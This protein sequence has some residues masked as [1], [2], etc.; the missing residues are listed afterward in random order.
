[1]EFIYKCP[2]CD[3]RL[4]LTDKSFVCDKL[5]TYDISKE[6]YVNLLLANQKNSK[7]PGDDKLMAESRQ[8]FLDK[9]YYDSLA[10]EIN[11]T[12][13]SLVAEG[14]RHSCLNILDVGCGVGFYS[15][16][17]KEALK[18]KGGE[19]NVKLWGIDISKPV[20]QKAAKRYGGIR[21]C[22]GSSFNLPFLDESADIVFSVFSPFD[23][24]EIFRVLKPGG[25]M[26]IVRP[27][28]GH[29]KELGMLIYDSFE[30]QGNPPDISA[31]PDVS[32]VEE[33]RVKYEI[34]LKNNADVMNLVD[35]TPYR[36]HLS[37]EKKTLL[38]A[39]GEL[40]TCADFQ[41]SLFKKGM[42]KKASD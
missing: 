15:G 2:V 8:S 3:Q 1:M 23:S 27:G 6:G 41:L 7:N 12:I 21:F 42:T 28:A 18:D 9:G 17:L 11:K 37:E 29:L 34:H 38:T 24:K 30:L 33:R 25:K 4:E 31:F 10:D 22:I 35:M 36:W 39:T 26:L 5:H 13:M 32:L 19:D 20:I 16:R 40:T 14:E